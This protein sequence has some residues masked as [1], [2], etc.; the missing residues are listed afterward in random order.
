MIVWLAG[1]EFNRE[2]F[3]KR[4]D[5]ILYSR[6]YHCILICQDPSFI[7][8]FYIRNTMLYHRRNHSLVTNFKNKVSKELINSIF[9]ISPVSGLYVRA[10]TV[11]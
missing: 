1:P 10:K 8:E 4:D 2:V 3:F 11:L 7:E 6:L 5:A 9:S